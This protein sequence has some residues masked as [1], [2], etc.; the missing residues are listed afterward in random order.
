MAYKEVLI[1]A[2]QQRPI[3]WQKSHEGHKKSTTTVRNN[4]EDVRN[5]VNEAAKTNFTCKH[6]IIFILLLLFLLLLFF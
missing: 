1:L 6:K 4:W 3:L 2:V 5:E